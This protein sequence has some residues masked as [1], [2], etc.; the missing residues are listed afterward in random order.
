M[1]GLTVACVDCG[2]PVDMTRARV[3][4]EMVGF[5]PR[6][7]TGGGL[8]RLFRRRETGRAM[9]DG[10]FLKINVP[11]GQAQGALL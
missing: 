10:C 4:V 2:E 11:G 9:C 3:V 5:A 7:R 6:T 8:N 1:S